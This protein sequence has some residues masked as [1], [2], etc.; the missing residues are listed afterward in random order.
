MQATD[1]ANKGISKA[2]NSKEFNTASLDK[3]GQTV[4]KETDR[5]VYPAVNKHQ[6]LG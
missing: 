4:E 6:R 3:E 1:I 2:F 5:E